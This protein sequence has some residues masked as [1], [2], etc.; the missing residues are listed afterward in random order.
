[1][2][3]IKYSSSPTWCDWAASANLIRLASAYS[4]SLSHFWL[5]SSILDWMVLLAL[6]CPATSS[7]PS[8]IAS[9]MIPCRAVISSSNACVVKRNQDLIFDFNANQLHAHPVSQ[10]IIRFSH[11][12][13]ASFSCVLITLP[14]SNHG[15]NF[16][17]FLHQPGFLNPEQLQVRG[18]KVK[19]TILLTAASITWALYAL[20]FCLNLRPYAPDSAYFLSVRC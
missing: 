19:A 13:A 1:M 4:L 7:S 10:V 14:S 20:R 16:T 5:T 3:C 6:C 11:Q 15:F 18:S 2:R 12:H 17:L 8:L 9:S